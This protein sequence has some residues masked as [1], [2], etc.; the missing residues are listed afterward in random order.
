MCIHSLI[1]LTMQRWPQKIPYTW[2][3]SARFK[4][5]CV[6]HMILKDL[7][8][9]CKIQTTIHVTS[10]GMWTV[11]VSRS[12]L[13]PPTPCPALP[14]PPQGFLLHWALLHKATGIR[15]SC[16]TTMQLLLCKKCSNNVFEIFFL[17]I[18]KKN[19]GNQGIYDT[20]Q[21]V[22]LETIL[23]FTVSVS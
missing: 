13:Q 19:G 14:I 9:H 21:S 4:T 20:L 22:P 5:C 12:L 10:S 16:S 17:V 6:I 18:R 7:P 23:S 15:V 8:L 3:K 1:T 2:F 11:S